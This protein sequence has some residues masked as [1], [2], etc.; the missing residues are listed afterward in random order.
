MLVQAVIK[1]MHEAG[2]DAG[3]VVELNMLEATMK[4]WARQGRPEGSPALDA[5]QKHLAAAL[6]SQSAPQNCALHTQRLAG[7]T[8]TVVDLH[9]FACWSSQLVI[10]LR[11]QQLMEQWRKTQQAPSVLI[12]FG[13]G[14]H[15]KAP[16]GGSLR[17]V[18]APFL[19]QFVQVT[20]VW[21]NGG[22]VRI[23]QGN[24]HK[25]FRSF[26]EQCMSFD[27][28][29]FSQSFEQSYPARQ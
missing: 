21:N 4:R 12:A 26:T 14:T 7:T 6:R 27:P 19:S 20:P 10:L 1:Q 22:A 23:R 16:F 28:Q 3:F 25:L 2:L 11:F 5:A 13:L 18:V 24:M 8:Y 9:G 15:R 29:T 17:R